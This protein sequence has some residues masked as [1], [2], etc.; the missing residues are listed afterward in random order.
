MT[1]IPFSHLLAAHRP[2]VLRAALGW[3]GDE[4]EAREVAQDVMLKAWAARDRYDPERPFYPW[5]RTIARNAARDAR[6]RG[7]HRAVSGLDAER[8]GAS[9]PGPDA[10]TLA[11]DANRHLRTALD[12]LP[13]EQREVLVLRHFEDLSYAEIAELLEVPEGTVMSRLFRA[14][15]ALAASLPDLEKR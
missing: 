4:Q 11:A 7:H 10:L 15:K 1:S 2:R 9:S 13:E 12:R 8:V 5:L 3:L 14:R 6:D